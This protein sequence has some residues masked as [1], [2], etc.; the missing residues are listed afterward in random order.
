[1]YLS[2]N[3]GQFYIMNGTQYFKVG[4]VDGDA[5]SYYPYCDAPFDMAEAWMLESATTTGIEEVK[6]ENGELKGIYD[7]SGR[8]LDTVTEP[9][10]YIINGKKMLVK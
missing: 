10:I 1:E 9:G 2:D 3:S 4:P 5:T 8:K 7:L 6:A